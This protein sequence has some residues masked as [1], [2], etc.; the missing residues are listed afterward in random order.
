MNQELTP[1]QMEIFHL[2]AKGLS[3]KEICELLGIS[4]NTVKIHVTGILR[5]LDVTNRT[6]AVF[7]YNEMMGRTAPDTLQERLRLVDRL[8]R[9]AL[10]VL[11]FE[12]L[13]PGDTDDYVLQGL[14]EELLVRLSAW[15]WFPVI[16]YASSR[17]FDP[18]MDDPQTMGSALG[19]QYL[20]YGSLR[21]HGQKIRITTRLVDTPSRREVWARNFDAAAEDLFTLQEEVARQIVA[22]MAPE[23]I[24][25]EARSAVADNGPVDQSAWLQVCKGMWHLAQ[26]SAGDAHEAEQCFDLAIEL[27]P[28]FSLG[29]HGRV[30]ALQQQLFE[31][32]T[33]DPAKTTR[34]LLAAANQGYQ[35]NPESA[36][37]LTDLGLANIL[38]GKRAVALDLLERAASFNPSS[39]RALSMLAQAQGM[40]GDLDQCIM[41]L[42]DLL[43]IDPHSRSSAR[44]R[45]IIAMCHNVAGRP[46]D[47]IQWGRDALA[48]DPQAAGAYLAMISSY[49]DLGDVDAAAAAVSALQEQ[50]PEFDVNRRL[51]MLRPFARPELFDKLAANLRSAGLPV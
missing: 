47:S 23:L 10:A 24:L 33:D 49:V 26:H 34:A 19:A 35:L 16:T 25:A 39:P 29:W 44:Y 3:N 13:Q 28:E 8:G 11:P 17:R 12:N 9:P 27:A 5:A 42:E 6:E 31:Q 32:W 15:R 36:Y 14:V 30:C 20:I 37:A 18:Q 45:T 51:D 22:V 46:D 4:A 48:R 21:R 43:R 2:M 7:V 50:H 41:H 38:Q 1:R 40:A